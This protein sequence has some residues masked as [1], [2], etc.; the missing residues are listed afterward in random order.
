MLHKLK[1]LDP[2]DLFVIFLILLLTGVGFYQGMTI[3][4]FK[5]ALIDHGGAYYAH[6]T[7]VFH[8]VDRE[9]LE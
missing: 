7:G 4:K 9:G 6:D 8:I 2:R 5:K 1:N 3:R